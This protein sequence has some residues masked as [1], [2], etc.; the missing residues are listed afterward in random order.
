MSDH[1]LKLEK[2]L[3]APQTKIWRYI[4]LQKL[5]S[6]LA[7]RALYFARPSSFHDPY[8]GWMPRSHMDALA[9]INQRYIEQIEEA[10]RQFAAH[11]PNADLARFNAGIDATIRQ[12]VQRAQNAPL[13]AVRKFGVS[14]WHKN[15]YESEAMWRTYPAES[16][17]I[18]ST[19][20]R[21]RDSNRS[22][23][24]INI[25]NVRYMDFDNDPIEKGHEQYL[26]CLKRK[27]FEHEKEL[28]A[29]VLLGDGIEG[30]FLDFDLDVLIA[31]IHLSPRA[32]E[33]FRQAVSDIL[34]GTAK[35]LDKPL[36][37]SSLYEK[38][39]YGINLTLRN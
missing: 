3:D 22:A 37:A 20:A 4:D 5:V 39:S 14:C 23:K 7:R 8:E 2:D 6:L 10:R 11:N 30:A 31:Q 32:S 13:E 27:S 12:Y 1:S 29:T 36:V 35:P 34:K 28:R 38:P 16:V 25:E 19:V 15:E 17:A 21:L 26:L 33:I 24:T 9:A 18:Q